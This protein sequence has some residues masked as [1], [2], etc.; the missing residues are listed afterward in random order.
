MPTEAQSPQRVVIQT[1]PPTLEGLLSFVAITTTNSGD[2]VLRQL[3]LQTLVIFP[4]ESVQSAEDLERLLRSSFAIQV[5]SERLQAVFDHLIKARQLLQP[6]GTIVTVKP[7]MRTSIEARIRSARDL[8]ARVKSQ[9]LAAAVEEFSALDGECAWRVLQEYLAGLFR[10]HGLQTVA[11]LDSTIAQEDDRADALKVQ[12]SHFVKDHCESAQRQVIESAIREFLAQV[13]SDPDRTRFLVQ[14]ADGA[15]S[16]YSLSAPPE[17]AERLRSHLK[18]LTLFLDTNFL[19]GILDLHDNPFGDIP[20]S[21]LTAIAKNN[22]P[23]KFRFHEAT[24]LE[25]R[26]TIIGITSDLKAR[27]WPAALSRAAAKSSNVSRIE[28]RFHEQN[29]IRTIDPETFFKLYEHLD[30][31]LKEQG[32]TIYRSPEDRL[33]ERSALIDQYTKVLK[34]R[35]HQKPYEAID[36]DMT[37]LDCVRRMRSSSGSTLDAKALIV[38]CDGYFNRFDR[39]SSRKNGDSPA[40]T[41]LPNHFLQLLRPFISSSDSFDRSF[42]ETFAIPEFRTLNSGSAKACSKLLALLATYRDVKEETVS[43]LLANDLL[44]DK[45]KASKSDKDF[46]DAVDAAIVA[47]NAVL[48]EEAMALKSQI[49]RENESAALEQARLMSET[50]RLRSEK[51]AIEQPPPAVRCCLWHGGHRSMGV[52]DPP[53]QFSLDAGS[54]EW[55][56]DPLSRFCVHRSIFSGIVPS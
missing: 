24:E 10:R 28:R 43:S 27:H 51:N 40:S 22:L 17:V 20:K 13:G 2:E 35:N 18:E 52:R 14:L 33:D 50:G 42:A 7:E 48:L 19:F 32:V 54:P 39:Q 26:R 53:L 15:F 3:A 9:W 34:S 41:I 4:N 11:L 8:Q 46:K 30:V 37:V 56:R 12:L 31:L 45:L 5:S 29:A 23:F 36:H 6:S 21:L 44:I 25:M 1:K 49:K 38:T 55:L 16:Y 47:E